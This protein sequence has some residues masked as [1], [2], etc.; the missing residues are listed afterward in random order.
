MPYASYIYINTY[1]EDKQ[2]EY[3]TIFYLCIKRFENYRAGSGIRINLGGKWCDRTYCHAVKFYIGHCGAFIYTHFD[4]SHWRFCG[5]WFL[6]KLYKANINSIYTFKYPKGCL[7]LPLTIQNI[8]V[9]IY[10]RQ[11]IVNIENHQI[12]CTV[13]FFFSSIN[14]SKNFLININ[15]CLSN[16]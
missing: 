7:Q 14:K 11:F 12:D 1:S 6:A 10:R 3:K 2:R 9:V 5:L 4:Y 16:S 13:T 8:K 15:D